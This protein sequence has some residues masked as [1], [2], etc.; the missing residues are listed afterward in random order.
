MNQA[1]EVLR[2]DRD[3]TRS[4]FMGD[5]LRTRRPLGRGAAVSKD[6]RAA[7]DLVRALA[8]LDAAYGCGDTERACAAIDT[9]RH[10]GLF[11]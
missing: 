11:R 8:D 3:A 2:K 5:L 7:W 10:I 4:R 6:S 9:I 1:E